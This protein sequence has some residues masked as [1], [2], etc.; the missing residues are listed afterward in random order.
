MSGPVPPKEAAAG[1][2]AM[3]SYAGSRRLGYEAFE[4]A[5]EATQILRRRFL[6][7]GWNVVSRENGAEL[8]HLPAEEG[9]RSWVTVLV[10][11]AAASAGF[12]ARILCHDRDV[13]EEL[14]RDADAE[15]QSIAL[16]DVGVE[17]ESVAF[18]RRYRLLVD[19][20]QD[21][22]ALRRLLSPELIADL[23]ALP[24]D[25]FSFELQDGALACFLTGV[26]TDPAELDALTDAA[27]RV[28]AAAEEVGRASPERR[29][30]PGGRESRIE[31]ALATHPFA[32]PPASVR[33]AAKAFRRLPIPGFIDAAA[34][35]L[36]AEA[37]FRTYVASIGMELSTP[38]AVKSTHY[39]AG[40][41]GDPVH[42]AHG[43]LPGTNRD[44]WL[45]LCAASDP[46]GD[47]W[48][49]MIVD[50]PY[51]SST[52]TW[53]GSED[54]RRAEELGME[55]AATASA[56]CVWKID[57]GSR[58]RTLA[59]V[60]AFVEFVAPLLDKYAAKAGSGLAELSEG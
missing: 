48:I 4:F 15:L 18:D 52:F 55:M 11:P 35:G 40:V 44:G 59:G 26:R 50:V 7:L 17:L 8:M 45:L 12:A 19:A 2:R 56:I 38:A 36:G 24:P 13:D 5:P 6:P 3:R 28:H 46:R 30:A 54:E 51:G 49:E 60:S 9:D 32:R 31:A 1:A 42:V 22:V 25:G 27:E 34:W 53:A 39:E 21:P 29:T 20:D 14:A 23:T 16:A 10:R 43:T 58:G 33:E 57:E 41:I 37:F 47:G